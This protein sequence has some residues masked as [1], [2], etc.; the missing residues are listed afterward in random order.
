[1]KVAA[2]ISREG[3]EAA[4]QA[5]M[6]TYCPFSYYA[7]MSESGRLALREALLADLAAGTASAQPLLQQAR[8]SYVPIRK[9]P[10]NAAGAKAEGEAALIAAFPELR[11]LV[12]AQAQTQNKAPA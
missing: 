9:T 12:H 11:K 6:A 10:V 8:A 5:F 1:M 4:V 7:S 3:K 2:S